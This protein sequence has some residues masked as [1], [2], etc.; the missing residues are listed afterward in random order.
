MTLTSLP[1]RQSARIRPYLLI[2]AHAFGQFAGL[3]LLAGLGVHR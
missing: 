3:A 2:Q 1:P